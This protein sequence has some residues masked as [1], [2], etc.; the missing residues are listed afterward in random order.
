MYCN[1]VINY[2]TK[3]PITID[4]EYFKKC[5]D[6]AYRHRQKLASEGK[7]DMSDRASFRLI[8]GTDE[9]LSN[10]VSSVKVDAARFVTIAFSR[11]RRRY[12]W[13]LRGYLWRIWIHSSLH[14]ALEGASELVGSYSHVP[15]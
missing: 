2:T 3:H 14:P 6:L 15:T 4:K 12:S 1:Q 5:I 13:P 11:D 7:L 10:S 9:I 8:N